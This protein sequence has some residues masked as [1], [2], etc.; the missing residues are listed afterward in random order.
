[1]SDDPDSSVF[2]SSLFS[3]MSVTTLLPKFGPILHRTL[4]V[5]PNILITLFIVATM[6]ITCSSQVSG[7][8][9]DLFDQYYSCT[10]RITSED[11]IFTAVME[12]LHEHRVFETH[13]EVGDTVCGPGKAWY[14]RPTR[15]LDANLDGWNSE[16]W[17]DGESDSDDDEE[18]IEEG[19][20]TPYLKI[21][22]KVKYAPT[23]TY[24][25]YFDFK[26]TGHTITVLRTECSEPGVFWRKQ[27]EHLTLRIYGRDAS[28]LKMLLQKVCDREN[29]KDV[30]RTT[31]F[32]AMQGQDG[33]RADWARCFSRAARPI[34]TVVL[35]EEQK[36]TICE[37]IREYLMPATKKW[38]ANR[39]LPYRRGYLLYGPPGT[40][41]TSLTV[42]LAGKFGLRVYSLSLS[43]VWM[44]DDTLLH[45]FSVLPK[46]CIVLLEDIDA[47]GITRE[48]ASTSS[49]PSP[50]N[51]KS[52][53]NITKSTPSNSTTTT[54][55]AAPA[56]VTFSGLL[57]AIDGVASKEGRL[58]IMTTNHRSHLDEALIRPGRVDLQ[59]KFNYADWA[60][61]HNLFRTLYTVE[62][63]DKAVLKFP[64][65][66]PDQEELL[67]LAGGFADKVPS[68]EF[69]PAEV[70]GLL[71]KYKKEPRKAAAEVETWVVQMREDRGLKAR[72]EKERLEKEAKER[73]KKEE[74][75]KRKEEEEKEAAK[76][77]LTN[78]V[79]VNGVKAE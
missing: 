34:E 18:D 47:C 59:I 5:D 27:K 42:A 49:D 61:I 48:S 41:K 62:D 51:N 3:A 54:T 12:Y 64:A 68:G 78:G 56:R 22:K 39:G 28:P 69:S 71:L 14:S 79:K 73:A 66:F 72:R 15:N 6:S 44:N 31:I 63:E 57:N 30:G 11:T 19:G 76:K 55:E 53:N 35:D 32:K 37:D 26:P 7:F 8:F 2:T 65:D 52:N 29:G 25:H 9:Y 67:E 74:E 20:E 16:I 40:G 4:G 24:T 58:L 17:D 36:E 75:E 43:A 10:I 77:P 70:Q 60:I 50:N 13:A 23:P 46:T 38:Y 45:L 21:R 33:D 1:M